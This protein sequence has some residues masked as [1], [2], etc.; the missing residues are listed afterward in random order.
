[1]TTIYILYPHNTEDDCINEVNQ[2]GQFTYPKVTLG[3]GLFTRKEIF[4]KL[5]GFYILEELIK[6]ESRVLEHIQIISS[7]G[8]KY[9]LD[10]FFDSISNADILR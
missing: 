7:K 2:L 10:K 6:K 1:M 9:T 4:T 3:G 5:A 8:K